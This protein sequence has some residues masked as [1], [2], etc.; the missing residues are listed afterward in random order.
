MKLLYVFYITGEFASVLQHM[1][2]SRC[3][4]PTNNTSTMLLVSYDAC[5]FRTV[6]QYVYCRPTLTF[7]QTNLMHSSQFT[8]TILSGIIFLLEMHIAL[9]CIP[10]VSISCNCTKHISLPHTFWNP[11][12]NSESCSHSS[13]IKAQHLSNTPLHHII[14]ILKWLKMG[15]GLVNG[16]IA[17]LYTLLETTSNYSTI[18]GLHTSQITTAHAKPQSFI[19]FPSHCLITAVNNG[20]SSASVLMMLPAG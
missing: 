18:A 10:S 9:S 20:D 6:N 19:V 11:K 3:L 8:W 1:Q 14:T 12:T 15:S 2:F 7:P 4:I 17:H 5:L 13:G 16:F